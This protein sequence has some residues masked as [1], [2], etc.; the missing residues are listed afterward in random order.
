MT[1]SPS[2][3]TAAELE[4]IERANDSDAPVVVFVHG[5]WLLSSSWDR[6]RDFFER[7]GH[8]TIAPG[9][10][11]DPETVEEGRANP[12]RF[13][14]NGVGEIT[15]HYV[16]AISRLTRPPAVVGHSFGGMIAQRLA[17]MG[18][19]SVTVPID[20]A[21]FRGVLPLPFSALKSSSPV[22]SNP[23]NRTRAVMLT[24]EQFRF[25]FV[26]AVDEEQAH[27]LYDEYPVPG[28]G[29]PLFQAALAN[30]NPK[31]VVKVDTRNPARGPMKIL[32]GELDHTVPWAI[33]NASYKKQTENP[34]VTGIQKIPGRGHS[35]VFDDG[36][37]DVAETTAAFVEAYSS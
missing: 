23:A 7:R 22:L 28:P 2:G 26:N 15:D 3:L 37:T 9:W 11:N 19:A 30:F 29:R 27:R 33:A 5:L 16:E 12:E 6:W 17:G 1:S 31:T 21:P 8:V 18:L 24:Y 14:G 20:P 25:A 35:L 36:W 4:Q 34:D 32:C 13:A 10:P